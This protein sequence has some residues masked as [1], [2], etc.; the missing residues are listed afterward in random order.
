MECHTGE[1]PWTTVP[2]SD[3]LTTLMFIVASD[4]SEAQG[5]RLTGSLSLKGMDVPAYTFEAARTVLW[6]L[7]FSPKS[8]TE[9][10]PLRVSGHG[11]SFNRTF[12]MEECSEDDFGQWAT[13]EITFE[14]SHVDDEKSCFWTWDANECAWRSRPFKSRH[15]K[16]REGKGKGQRQIQKD[17]KSILRR[18]TST[19]S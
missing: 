12:I 17:G 2:L 8:S 13:D 18:R 5:E 16:R 9:N 3:H 10:P 1:H 11:G 4:L 7:F 15:L 14:Q 19:R 6:E